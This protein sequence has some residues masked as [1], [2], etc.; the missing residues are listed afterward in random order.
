MRKVTRRGLV[1]G[2]AVAAA[3]AQTADGRT[4]ARTRKA[5]VCVVGAG[6]AGL[7][8][9]RRLA[10]AGRSVVVLE[11]RNRVGGRVENHAL[12]GGA[13]SERGGTFVGPTQDRVYAL[14]KELGLTTFDVYDTGQNVYIS[15][16]GQ[17][18]TW[19]DTGPTGTAPLD[20]AILPDL[21][22]AVSQLDQLSTE[23]PVDAPWTAAKAEE[24]D[25]QTLATWLQANS[26]N[27]D[28]RKVANVATRAIFGAETNE[29]SLLYTLFYIAASGNETTPGT[30]ERN[31][32][33]RGGAQQQRVVGGTQTIALRMAQQLGRRIVTGAPVRRIEQHGTTVTVISDKVTVK[34]KHV[35]VALPPTLAGRI[36][37]HPQ[38]PAERDQLTQ[39]V[40]QGALIKVA[41]T[42]TSPFWREQ[43]L[44]GSAVAVPGLVNVTFDDSPPDGRPGIVFG[45]V[46][47]DNARRYLQLSAQ[48]RRRTVLAEFTELFGGRASAPTDFFETNWMGEEWSRGCPV[49]IHPP[50]SLTAYGPW[51]RR[52]LGRIHWAGTETSTY[53]S[54]YMDGAIRSGERAAQEIIG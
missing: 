23:V 44:T 12:P 39:R 42:Y 10:A 34:A 25:S 32:N 49:A 3:A 30:F 2:A 37:Y 29:L 18:S 4:V 35:V 36:A 38:L 46:G 45:F 13:I 26:L 17:R 27:P 52:P 53:W 9:A 40:P 14:I 21:T 50:G 15:S 48:D 31:F 5:D 51:L 8:A 7:T 11:A 20:P 28:F 43:G 24:Y 47:G 16:S 22:L 6:F 54:G 41:A 33:T 19:S 1:G